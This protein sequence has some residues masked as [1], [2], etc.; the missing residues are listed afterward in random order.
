MQSVEQLFSKRDL[1]SLRSDAP[2]PLYHQTYMLLRDRIL[3]GSIPK[4]TQMPTEQRLAEVFGVSRITAKR[5]MD[6]LAAQQLVERRRG[7]GTHVT[8]QYQAEALTAPITGMLQKLVSMGRSTRVKV[9][10]VEEVIPPADLKKELN[11]ADGE[12]A[13]KL[14]RVRSTDEGVPF[15]YYVS[16]T[17]GISKGFSKEELETSV[18]LDVIRENG[19]ELTRIEQNL[20]AASV[21]ADVAYE[22]EMKPGD[23]A[24]TLLRRSYTEGGQLVD[25]LHCQYNPKRFNYQMSLN[26]DEYLKTE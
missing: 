22:L 26:M 1:E 16:W 10:A 11:L 4:G 3:D 9:L 23:P 17:K 21:T 25:I 8:H 2:T 18:R 15:A 24:L 20:G 7:K 13:F 6:E 12:K 19:M 5:A 14:I